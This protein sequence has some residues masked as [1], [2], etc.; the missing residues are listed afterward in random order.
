M[1]IP[2][3]IARCFAVAGP[4]LP[5]NEHY[6]IGNFMRDS[7]C[8][9][10]IIVTGDGTPRRSFLYLADLAWWLWIILT[11]GKPGRAYNVGSDE[12]VSIGDLARMIGEAC[13]PPVPVKILTEPVPGAEPHSFVP[14]VKRALK[15]LGL[16]ARIRLDEAIER[17]L[18]WHKNQDSQ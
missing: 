7:L 1:G 11:D 10:E 3:R 2:T 8:G 13:S 4:K 9:D 18:K 5:L 16:H 15:E 17:T 14:S 12:S 6:A